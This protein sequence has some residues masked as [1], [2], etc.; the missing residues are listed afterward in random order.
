MPD[1]TTPAAIPLHQEPQYALL[2]GLLALHLQPHE[3][4]KE[5]SARIRRRIDPDFPHEIGVV[6]LLCA[7]MGLPA[8]LT[9]VIA[10]AIIE[11]DALPIKPELLKAYVD[12]KYPP[13]D[14]DKT[15]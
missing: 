8:E 14:K 7:Q 13:A 2:N 15:Q 12:D 6:I 11:R 1:D 10:S 3:R 9:H 5:W 4:L